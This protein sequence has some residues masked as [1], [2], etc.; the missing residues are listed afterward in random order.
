MAHVI[1]VSIA[2]SDDKLTQSEWSAYWADVDLVVQRRAARI[3]GVWVSPSFSPYQNACWC[4]DCGSIIVV[5]GLREDLRW[6]AHKY[7]QDS[8]ALARVQETEFING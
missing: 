1:Y 4:I 2:N 8:I 7:K 6:L 5:E 3:H